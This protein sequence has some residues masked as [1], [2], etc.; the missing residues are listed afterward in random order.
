MQSSS[1]TEADPNNASLERATMI[2][3]ETRDNLT[4]TENQIREADAYEDT[5]EDGPTWDECQCEACV[6]F[7]EAEAE[8]IRNSRHIRFA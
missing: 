3:D 5:R 1:T 6:E 4:D 2:F 7:S 8:H